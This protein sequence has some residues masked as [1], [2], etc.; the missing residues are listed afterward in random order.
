MAERAWHYVWTQQR[1]APWLAGEWDADWPSETFT[2]GEALPPGPL[3]SLATFH[4][5]PWPL[6]QSFGLRLFS[7][8][9]GWIKRSQPFSSVVVE[10]PAALT[11]GQ[12]R[13][14][15]EAGIF[16]H[17]LSAEEPL[18]VKV[19]APAGDG[20]GLIRLYTWWI[21]VRRE[22]ERGADGIWRPV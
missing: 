15:G 17:R 13:V 5:Q 22:Y 18:M 6:G 8:P 11:D 16:Y 3:A 1:D 10:S 4:N 7:V 2:T 21:L 20:S 19:E 12:F 9:Q 14:R